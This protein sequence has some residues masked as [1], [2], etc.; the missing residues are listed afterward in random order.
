VKSPT[1]KFAVRTA[2]SGARRLFSGIISALFYIFLTACPS[3]TET[4]VSIES[5]LPLAL[6]ETIV[7]FPA[8]QEIVSPNASSFAQCIRTK[9]ERYEN[10]YGKIMDTTAFQN[11]LFPWFEPEHA[12]GTIDELNILLSRPEV[13]ERISSLKVRYLI[14]MAISKESDGFPGFVCGAGYGGAGCL[15]LGWE[16]KDFAMYAIVWDLKTGNE[17]GELTASSTGKSLA[18]GIG[19]PIIFTAYT[20]DDA[21][22]ALAAALGQFLDR[23]PKTGTSN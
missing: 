13:R 17:A 5:D 2:V 19:I 9:I 12:P 3:A 15:G 8:S 18:I 10:A 21:C 6:G 4:D 23:P 7:L 11:A 14:S 20:E 1:T 16:N 22:E